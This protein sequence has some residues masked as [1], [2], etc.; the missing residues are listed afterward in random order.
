MAVT[1]SSS[2][3]PSN[4]PSVSLVAYGYEEGFVA[5]IPKIDKIAFTYDIPSSHREPVL[6]NLYGLAGEGQTFQ[7]LKSSGNHRYH[8]R[9]ALTHPASGEKILIEA[10]PK[11]AKGAKTK[12]PAFLRL[13]LNPARL[14]FDGVGFLRDHLVQVFFEEHPWSLVATNCTVT[15]MDLAVDLVGVRSDS[16][17]I[18]R[19]L[20][21]PKAQPG[22]KWF[23][24]GASGALETAYVGFKKG[25]I[26]P[27]LAYDKAQELAD[28]EQLAQF[29][30]TPHA[31]VEFRLQPNR[32]IA[33]LTAMKNPFLVASVINPT[34]PATAPETEHA[35]EFFLDC[36]RVRGTK[37]ALSLLP[38][39]E[40]RQAYAEALSTADQEVWKPAKLW[41]KWLTALEKSGL[42][43]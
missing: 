5:L 30:K 18:E 43:P 38:T 3:A 27:L 11:V 22:K 37:R 26:A 9:F 29:G 28:K 13:E 41:A 34:K 4:K 24:Y 19:T 32:S 20:T 10:E 21:G 23:I 2:S 25:K 12:P 1:F 42:L 40:L 35:W 7:S 39:D 16:L 31:R 15:R 33:T 36:C 6:A 8:K 17:L 14:G